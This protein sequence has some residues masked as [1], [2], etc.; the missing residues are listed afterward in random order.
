MP[1]M[2]SKAYISHFPF[3]SKY[4]SHATFASNLYESEKGVTFCPRLCYS[5]EVS[6]PSINTHIHSVPY[7]YSHRDTY[8]CFSST[9]SFMIT[10][11]FFIFFTNYASDEY[12]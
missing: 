1:Y 3:Y 12:F 11:L 8:L 2:Y 7:T 10:L 6:P 4:D 9:Q 5:V